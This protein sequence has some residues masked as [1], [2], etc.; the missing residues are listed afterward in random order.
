MVN[1]RENQYKSYKDEEKGVWNSSEDLQ[2]KL[3]YVGSCFHHTNK[4]AEYVETIS[5]RQYC[6]LCA[7]QLA[8]LGI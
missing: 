5:Q 7:A 3:N 6:K 4:Y 2:E 8:S 1:Q